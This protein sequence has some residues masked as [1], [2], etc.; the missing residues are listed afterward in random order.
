ME[1]RFGVKSR[2]SYD[3]DFKQELTTMLMSGRSAR[4]LSQSF[5]IAENLLY[6]WKSMATMKTKTKTG[7]SESSKSAKLA[8][9]NARLRAENER[10]K[11]DR[12]ILKKALGLF[13]KSD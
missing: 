6:R 7:D 12:E 2:R 11:T 13:S 4:E 3:A 8:A 5:G 1:K 9:E 10:L